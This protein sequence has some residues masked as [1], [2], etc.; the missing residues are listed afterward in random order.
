MKKKKILSVAAVLMSIGLAFGATGCDQI[1]SVIGNFEPVSILSIEKT[2]TNGLVD[3]YTIYYTNG[4]TTTFQVTNGSN[5]SNGT[6]GE[7]GE[8]GEDGSNGK[9]VTVMALYE[10]YKE[11]YGDISYAEFLSLYLSSEKEDGVV[12]NSVLRSTAKVYCEFLKEKGATEDDDSVTKTAATAADTE[13][14][15]YMGSSVIYRID[16]EY[17]YF[18]TNYHVVYEKDALD[19]RI[20]NTIHCYLY[21]SEGGPVHSETNTNEYD[22]GEYAIECTF[23]GG[24]VTYDLAMLRAK[25]SDVKTLN[26]D[27]KA[28]TFAEDYYVG[29]MAITV[30]NANGEGLSV[31]K[32]IVSM[33]DDNI[34]LDIDG[35]SR[36]YRSIR[37]D[38]PLYKGNS[39]GGVFN[40]NGELIGI[41]NAGN[42]AQQNVNFAI[43]LPIVRG[44]AQNIYTHFSDGDEETF[45]VYKTTVGVTV[46]AKNAK[47]VYDEASGYGRIVEDVE[48]IEI[49]KGSIVEKMGLAAGDFIKK[50]K[51]GDK[52]YAISRNADISD[53]I[54]LLTEG[55]HFS[56]T[57]LRDGEEKQSA[58]YIIKASDLKQVD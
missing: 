57:Y 42:L 34:L 11:I 28:V 15:V 31:T 35:T 21:G 22:Y 10:K 1:M 9:D 7:D 19:S 46:K 12:I 24:S 49:T 54:L 51:V 4:T 47:Y 50:M 13:T 37:M 3:T 27:V 18:L 48:V 23:V 6:P 45:G 52:E 17:T 36:T 30:G 53:V 38:T 16:E 26:P 25:T 29:Q 2:A 33:K 20:S 39:G 44:V 40:G 43:P 56:F 32:G 58:G 5:G 41:A 14:A 8:D 55:A